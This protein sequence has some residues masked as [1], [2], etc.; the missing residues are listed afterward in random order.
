MVGPGLTDEGTFSKKIF[1]LD[2]QDPFLQCRN[3]PDFPV[4]IR[5]PVS[6]LTTT[7]TPLIC[8]E[9]EAQNTTLCFLYFEG[10][11]MEHRKLEAPSARLV[12]MLEHPQLI[13]MVAWNSQKFL[14][15]TGWKDVYLPPP[16]TDD[17]PAC[18]LE[19]SDAQFGLVR[20][21]NTTLF[22]ID[23]IVLRTY[24]YPGP[25]LGPE[26]MSSSSCSQ[27]RMGPGSSEQGI[28]IV[29]GSSVRV[30]EADLKGPWKEG[31]GKVLCIECRLQPTSCNY[32]SRC[33]KLWLN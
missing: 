7:N 29:A 22:Q 19:Y 1:I 10:Q 20:S 27:I 21:S 26:I 14:D 30:M 17:Q 13:R 23:N 33:L 9:A 5:N 3:F 15:E 31:P 12:P 24:S 6:T 32:S 25:E 16:R 28:I 8:G 11:W 18:A 2:I 4:I